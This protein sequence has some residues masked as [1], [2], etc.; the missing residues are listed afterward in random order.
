MILYDRRC[1]PLPEEALAGVLEALNSLSMLLFSRPYQI[2]LAF[3]CLLYQMD[4]GIGRCLQR[5]KRKK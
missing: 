1:P 2:A 5:R 3:L 4:Y